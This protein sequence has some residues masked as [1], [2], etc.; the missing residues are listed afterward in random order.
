MRIIIIGNS[1][2]AV[3]AI[4]TIRQ[5]DQQA[6]ILAISEE[7]HMIY[8]RPML[9]H[10]LAG[11]VDR[12]HLAY[13]G[14]DFYTRHNVQPLLN[15]RVVAI[16]TAAHTVRIEAG[17]SYSYDKLL[18]C[19]GGLPIVPPLP[20]LGAEGIFTLTRLDD[21]LGITQ[22]LEE[23]QDSAR[24]VRR[25]VVVGGGMIGIKATDALMKRHFRVTMVE[26]APRILSAA[27]DETASQLLTTLL[28][29]QGV[30]V[31]T[32][33]TLAAIR[34]ENGKIAAVETRDGQVIPC[35]LLV[36]GIGVR[37]NADL[38]K[39][40][41]ITVNRGIVVDSYMRTSAPDVY[42]AGDV[43]EAYDLVVDMNRIVAIWPNAYRQ[44]AIAGAH[45]VGV[46]RGDEGGVAM[47]TVEVCGVPAIS[48]GN[49]NMEGDPS[50]G[51]EVLVELR[52]SEHRYKRLVLK[53]NRLVG[54]ILV[55]NIS[56]A[57]IYTGLIRNRLDVSACRRSLLSEHFGLLSLPDQYRKHIVTGVGIEV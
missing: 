7:P 12:L 29:E 49:G 11:E 28:R 44:G 40:A 25:A 17:N 31:L 6:E 32:N 27:L 53:D 46:P 41:A 21:A 54:A 14:S 38:A 51:Y 24:P 13:R 30:Q 52:M 20:G 1:A 43:A 56:R 10:F 36:F 33:N 57:G 5:H 19:T 2:T 16:D 48:I 50:E 37:P 26:L 15:S 3:G 45:I 39:A 35:E 23:A 34:S 22:H 9:S 4:E 55:G 18:I 47:N 42:G 8:S